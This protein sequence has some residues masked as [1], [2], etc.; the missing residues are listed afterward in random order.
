MHLTYL[1]EV[2]SAMIRSLDLAHVLQVIIEGVNA[3]LE[4]ERTSVFLIDSDTN[5][6]VLRYTTEGDADIRL[7]AP[8]QG[9]AGWVATYDQPALVNDTLSDPRY[10]RQIALETGYEA[11]SIL[12]VPL[13]VEGQMI[14]VI[15]VLNKTGDQQFNHYH[16]VLLT[17]LTQWAAIALH[18]AR[19][20]DG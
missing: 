13:K 8:W 7:P 14:G 12:C 9:I 3:L 11:N 10:L 18:N 19:L 1:N 20:F 15:E 5:E 6:L 2:G 17:D 16:Q 4:T